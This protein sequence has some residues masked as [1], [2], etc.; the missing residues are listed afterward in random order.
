M[1]RK[2]RKMWYGNYQW[3]SLQASHAADSKFDSMKI[4]TSVGGVY[5]EN[6]TNVMPFSTVKVDD[7]EGGYAGNSENW[8]LGTI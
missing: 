5:F 7:C 8:Q 3:R 1:H 6:L 2:W 4:R